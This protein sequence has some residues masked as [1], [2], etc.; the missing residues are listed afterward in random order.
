MVGKGRGEL[1]AGLEN[2]G[3]VQGQPKQ[4]GYK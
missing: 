2:A 3:R 1:M 4:E